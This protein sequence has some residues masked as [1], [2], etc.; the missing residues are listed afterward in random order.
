LLKSR[1]PGQELVKTVLVLDIK[2]SAEQIETIH[3]RIVTVADNMD[4]KL[5][6]LLIPL[7]EV[8]HLAEDNHTAAALF[9]GL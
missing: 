1:F 5:K 7:S 9:K 2:L 8:R 6:T 4:H 3:S